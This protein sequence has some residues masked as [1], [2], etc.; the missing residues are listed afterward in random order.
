MVPS[1]TWGSHILSSE[2]RLL[3]PTAPE[4]ERNPLF[5]GNPL[6]FLHR[7]RVTVGASI[8]FRKLFISH[9]G[10]SPQ[11]RGAMGPLTQPSLVPERH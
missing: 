11:G 7:E 1:Y 10:W 6:P 5:P 4:A 2:F 8:F 9:M 3:H